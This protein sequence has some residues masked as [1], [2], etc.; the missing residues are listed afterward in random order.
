MMTETR[1]PALGRVKDLAHK[2]GDVYDVAFE[3]HLAKPTQD[4]LMA[5]GQLYLHRLRTVEPV[6]P[7]VY[8]LHEMYTHAED[9]GLKAL[10]L[11]LHLAQDNAN[12]T[13]LAVACADTEPVLLLPEDADKLTDYRGNP[14]P[15][16][17]LLEEAISANIARRPYELARELITFSHQMERANRTSS[18]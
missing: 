3:K 13:R 5:N 16:V 1:P 17:A 14:E 18:F 4:R 15:A 10:A 7:G 12:L 6:P 8:Y 9:P 11:R 2:L